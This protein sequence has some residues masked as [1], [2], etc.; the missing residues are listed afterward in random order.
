L[1]VCEITSKWAVALRRQIARRQMAARTAYT[2]YET[3]SWSDCWQQASVS[4]S[5]AVVLEATAANLPQL[6]REL[7]RYRTRLPHVPVIV[8]GHRSLSAS[9][10]LIRELGA[11][12][13][14]FSSRALGPV[15]RILQRHWSQH[16]GG[17]EE[18]DPWDNLPWGAPAGHPCASR[19]DIPSWLTGGDGQ[20]PRPVDQQ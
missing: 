6:A 13:V 2:L 15:V 11:V 7:V 17:V 14:V 3:R 19:Q 10:W 1:V 18:A 5:S 8:V 9:R 20:R 12:H 16:V 4:S